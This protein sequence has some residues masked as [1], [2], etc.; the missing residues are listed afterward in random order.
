[1]PVFLSARGKLGY[2]LGMMRLNDRLMSAAQSRDTQRIRR[3]L[4]TALDACLAYLGLAK[5]EDRPRGR[6]QARAG[7]EGRA[8]C[9]RRSASGQR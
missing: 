9:C 7:A 1:V 6:H 5:S 2:V 3:E 4:A 8:S